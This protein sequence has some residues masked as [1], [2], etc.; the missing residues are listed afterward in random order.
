MRQCVWESCN[1]EESLAKPPSGVKKKVRVDPVRSPD[2]LFACDLLQ[3][4]I[5]RIKNRFALIY[6]WRVISRHERPKT[7]FFALIGLR[8]VKVVLFLF[9]NS[10]CEIKTWKHG[11]FATHL[12]I[13]KVNKER[14]SSIS[15]WPRG[16]C[17]IPT[18]YHLE[19][20][21]LGVQR[22]NWQLTL[23]RL[24]D[25]IF[26]DSITQY[27]APRA[28]SRSREKVNSLS[29]G[30][31]SC[32]RLGFAFGFSRVPR[33]HSRRIPIDFREETFNRDDDWLNFNATSFARCFDIE[34]AVLGFFSRGT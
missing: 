11:T 8:Q 23:L 2:L 7:I 10:P 19:S 4:E 13:A 27:T 18:S 12:D 21:F 14:N 29:L 26:L 33:H 31:L 15:R 30:C 22:Q 20:F 9:A 17:H 3:F 1:A 5:L 6:C 24:C 32:L 34:L 16:R 25:E 28:R